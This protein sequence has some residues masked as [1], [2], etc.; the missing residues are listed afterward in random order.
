MLLGLI[1]KLRTEQRKKA[2]NRRIRREKVQRQKKYFK[3]TESIK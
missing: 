3:I 2:E 1:R